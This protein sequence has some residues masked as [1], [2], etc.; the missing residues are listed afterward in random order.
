[1]SGDF[2]LKVRGS[3]VS[4]FSVLFTLPLYMV[5]ALISILLS[6]VA[7]A[8]LNDIPALSTVVHILVAFP[9]VIT[10]LF[11][12]YCCISITSVTLTPDR[13]TVRYCG[14]KMLDIPASQIVFFSTIC[15]L[16]E[17]NICLSS[18][19]IDELASLQEKRMRRSLLHRHDLPAVK[20]QNDWRAT[21]ARDYLNRLR[22]S[23]F[24]FVKK[25]RIIFL[26]ADPALQYLIHRMYPQLTYRNMTATT[27]GYCSPY[28]YLREDSALSF[29]VEKYE[30][31]ASIEEDGIHISGKNKEVGFIPSNEIRSV[32]RVD[33]S[34]RPK[35]PN[36]YP[37]MYIS[38]LSPEELAATAQKP[39]YSGIP[40]TMPERVSVM[41]TIAASDNLFK[42]ISRRKDS[43]I[44]Y[45]TEGNLKKIQTLCPNAE[46]IN[47]SESWLNNIDNETDI[48]I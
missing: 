2:C 37:V 45:Y 1:M 15:N 31:Y 25:R 29:T 46:I 17:K 6:S 12:I 47:I 40:S 41:A 19:S 3:W 10:V 14:I 28:D 48:D 22:F 35:H 13:I 36:N 21:L 27:S 26:D 30:L 38:R 5:I 42:P 39:R 33:V 34:Y 43:C 4:S 18:Y 8:F 44:M 7:T 23:Y 24:A 16:N 32:V 11:F 9:Y 20:K